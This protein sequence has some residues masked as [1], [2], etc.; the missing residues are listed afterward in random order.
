VGSVAEI[1][2]PLGLERVPDEAARVSI[3]DEQK[4]AGRGEGEGGGTGL[5]FFAVAS[6]SVE[7]APCAE[8]EESGGAV[9]RSGGEG[10]VVG[11][12]IDDVDVRRVDIEYMGALASANIPR[13]NILV[14]TTRGE[15][16]FR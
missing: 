16:V 15:C 4:S 6:I 8:I 7:F 1:P 11:E 14:A 5:L 10:E 12:E 13:D 9:L 2:F 3:R